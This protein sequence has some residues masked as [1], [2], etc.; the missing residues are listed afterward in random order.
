[1]KK[2]NPYF[3]FLLVALGLSLG[4][5]RPDVDDPTVP[6]ERPANF[7]EIKASN[8]FSWETSRTVLVSLTGYSSA[9]SDEQGVLVLSD[10]NGN[11][12][13]KGMHKTATTFQTELRLPASVTELR[14]QFGVCDKVLP[15]SLNALNGDLLPV[16]PEVL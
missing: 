10:L 1:M 7:N 5:C 3:V 2:R 16:L 8:T 13:Y 11:I 15:L 4:A 14:V 6:V 12:V 9:L